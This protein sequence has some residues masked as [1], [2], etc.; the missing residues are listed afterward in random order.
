MNRA[1]VST[2]FSVLLMAV[3]PAFAATFYV[4]P[5]LDETGQPPP[6][7]ALVADGSSVAPFPNVLAAFKAGAVGGDTIILKP[8][9]HGALKLSDIA[10]TSPVIIK[11][12][13]GRTARFDSIVL[14]GK[15]KN[16]TFQKLGV[17]P[18]NV[19][20]GEG[21][22]G[23]IVETSP[24][25]SNI[26][27]DSITVRSDPDAANYRNWDAAM[28]NARKFSGMQLAGPNSGVSNS[29]FT[30]VYMGISTMG[31]NALVV[32]NRVEGYNG[33]GLRG[34]GRNNVFRYNVVVDCVA[35][36]DNHDDG[37]QSFADSTGV[38]SGLVLDGNRIY[39]WTGPPNPLSCLLQGIGMFDGFYDDLTIINNVVSANQ[40]HGISVYGARRALIAN[41]TV[42][43]STGQPGVTPYIAVFDH[44]NGAHPVD[45][46]V[47][48]NL[49]MSIRGTAS[50]ERNVVFIDNSAIVSPMAEFQNALAFDYRPLAGSIYIDTGD[51]A[52]GPLTDVRGNA[53]PIGKGID[54]GAYE[55]PVSEKTTTP[56][57]TVTSSG[58]T[59]A[60]DAGAAT[61]GT[62]AVVNGDGT[63]AKFVPAP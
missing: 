55:R 1:F 31:E 5:V 63:T 56:V 8:G 14:L 13:S 22:Q 11:S 18:S 28:W 6:I 20:L 53:R 60:V 23:Y 37:F 12:A 59:G 21:Y 44:K 35:T 54:R 19:G 38:L 10:P 45:I 4:A 9:Y 36:D 52:S 34:L 43:N 40:Y 57:T 58:A 41:N 51:A 27:F 7:T 33:D 32:G 17:W 46:L 49:A 2:L 30:G 26:F 61:S 16:L 39:E 62:T 42:V 15:T 24:T 48:N 50:T 3:A 25:T 29:R 47:A